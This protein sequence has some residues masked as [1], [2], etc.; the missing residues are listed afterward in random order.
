MAAAL[1]ALLSAAPPDVLA[2]LPPRLWHPQEAVESLRSWSAPTLAPAAIDQT[3]SRAYAVGAA[4]LRAPWWDSFARAAPP[5]ILGHA[6]GNLD[7]VIWDG[8]GCRLVDFEDSGRSDLAWELADVV[9]H[10]SGSLDDT[11]DAAG[12]LTHFE[13]TAAEATRL[14]QARCVHAFHWLLML[15]PA[16]RAQDR[17]PPGTLEWQAQRFLDRLA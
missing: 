14:E 6:D 12:F 16:G 13:L 5:A 8:R 1:K 9:E 11:F 2:T 10:L 15:L 7:N 3:V 4:L 17:N